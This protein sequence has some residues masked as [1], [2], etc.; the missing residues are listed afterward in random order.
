MGF[1]DFISAL[2]CKSKSKKK[3]KSQRENSGESGMKNRLPP[4]PVRNI[5]SID[6]GADMQTRVRVIWFRLSENNCTCIDYV[7][8][9]SL[10]HEVSLAS[11][12]QQC[13]GYSS[14]DK[15]LI[16]EVSGEEFRTRL[17]EIIEKADIISWDGFNGYNSDIL[18]GSS[19]HFEALLSNGERIYAYGNNCFPKTYHSFVE[20]LR[21]LVERKLL[22]NR[23]FTH[24]GIQLLLP[25]EWVG[26]VSVSYSERQVCFYFE[27]NDNRIYLV[28]LRFSWHEYYYG[29]G[30]RDGI[31]LGEFDYKGQTLFF[32][33]RAYNENYGNYSS[34]AHA[35][36]PKLMKMCRDVFCGNA[37][38]RIAK[39]VKAVD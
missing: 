14:D 4:K 34:Q 3:K 17:S 31:K 7:L 36:S 2:F 23:E 37:V 30:D 19:M 12:T 5:N 35:L 22:D 21:K 25:E 10:Q 28:A 15:H 11:Y 6:N 33:I 1:L 32:W 26:V 39:S 29:D 38:K 27:I 24:M 13:G 9:G 8:E 16:Y 18:D 20:D